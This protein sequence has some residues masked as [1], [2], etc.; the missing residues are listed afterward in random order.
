MTAD[1]GREE[2]VATYLAELPADAPEAAAAA[3]AT[4][5]ASA[6]GCRSRASPT[7]CAASTGRSST[8]SAPARPGRG[9]AASPPATGGCMRIR[10]AAANFGPEFPMPLTTLVG[11]DPS[12]VADRAPRGRR[13]A[14]AP[15]RPRSR[16]RGSASRAGAGPH[17]RPRPAAA[18]QHDQAVHRVHAPAVGAALLEQVARGGADLIK[19]DELLADRRSTASPD[20]A[21]LYRRPPRPGGGGDGPPGPLRGQRHDQD[22]RASSTPPGRPLETPARTR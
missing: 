11:N 2:L 13:P 18:A 10:F 5:R 17:R 15:S 1:P 21:R 20:R 22:G 19:D 9:R 16:A 8:R 3:F 14:A 12:D 4:A 6:P 7:R